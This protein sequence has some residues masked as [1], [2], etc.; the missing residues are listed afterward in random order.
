MCVPH[1]IRCLRT[2]E[3]VVWPQ[4][5]QR[6]VVRSYMHTSV[7]CK[8]ATQC[9]LLVSK[10]LHP[11][12]QLYSSRCICQA[13]KP[14]TGTVSPYTSALLYSIRKPASSQPAPSALRSSVHSCQHR[15]SFAQQHYCFA[16]CGLSPDL[17]PVLQSQIE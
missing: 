8:L 2:R 1:I 9:S 14:Q 12:Q 5:R 17:A 10:G 4:A 7:N 15:C 13:H 16:N 3:C 6:N 11:C